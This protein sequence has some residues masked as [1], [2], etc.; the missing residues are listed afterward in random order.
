MTNHNVITLK[1]SDVYSLSLVQG[2]A[3]TNYTDS[4]A[5]L[6]LIRTDD[7]YDAFV[8]PN[9]WCPEWVGEDYLDDVIVGCDAHDLGDLISYAKQYVYQTEKVKEVS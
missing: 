6:S 9:A 2:K 4:Y 1:L 8:P 7:V 3:V 5:E